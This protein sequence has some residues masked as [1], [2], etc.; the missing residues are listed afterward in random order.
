MLGVGALVNALDD[1]VDSRAQQDTITSLNTR[2]I[3]LNHELAC[4]FE[5]TQPVEDA[6]TQ[7]AAVDSAKLD[8]LA[9]GLAA[10]AR[11]D[12]AGVAQAGS[13]IDALKTQSD[14]AAAQLATAL[15]ERADAVIT[16]DASEE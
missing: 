7:V 3:Q 16:C 4:R 12:D 10:F 11:G 14:E 8:A 6:R 9:F 5:V 1:W 2:I 13:R 15:Q